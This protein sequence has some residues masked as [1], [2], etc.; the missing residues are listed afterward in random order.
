M[1]KIITS[2]LIFT[3][4]NIFSQITIQLP[5]NPIINKVPS[6]WKGYNK[7]ANSNL[8]WVQTQEFEEAFNELNPGIIRWPGGNYANSY[9]W[10]DHLTD[11]NNLNLKSFVPFIN[12]FGADMQIIVNFGNGSA[13]ESAEFVRFCNS[14]SKKYNELRNNVFN[15][16]KSLNVKFWEIGNENTD[17]WSFANSWFG[18]QENIY[19]QT[20]NSPHSMTR[21]QAERLY[22]YGGSFF[23]EGWVKAVAMNFEE[24]ILGD[25]KY[26]TKY[27]LKDTLNIKYP[28]LDKSIDSSIR[29]FRTKNFDFNWAKNITSQQLLYDSIS[30]TKNLLTSD[31][32][33]W[34]ET[35]VFLSPNG[36]FN[37]KDFILIEYNSTGHDGAFVFRDSMKAADPTI[38]VGYNSKINNELAN[39]YNFQIDFATSPPDFI[40]KHPYSGKLTI[41]FV[42][43]NMFSESAYVSE[44]K[45]QGFSSLQKTWN[46]RVV[47]WNIPNKIGIS[48]TEWNIA[49]YDKAP[50]NHPI[51]GI[52]SGLYVADFWA[53]S[54][55]YALKDSFILRTMNHFAL[56]TSGNNFIH[57]FHTNNE[58]SV[59]VEGKATT[60]V[61]QALSEGMFDIPV[62]NIPNINVV[63]VGVSSIDTIEVKAVSIFGGTGK[64]NEFINLLLINRDD[65]NNHS[66]NIEIPRSWNA[67]S[68]SI[69]TLNGTMINEFI[70]NK[71]MINKIVNNHISLNLAKYSVNTV[72]IRKKQTTINHKEEKMIE[73]I[74]PNPCSDFLY[75]NSSKKIKSFKIYNSI[76]QNVYSKSIIRTENKIDI[77]SLTSGMYFFIADETNN[78]FSFI[79]S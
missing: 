54:F 38:E 37:A 59:G 42:E 27:K 66:V 22:Y 60:M 58:F 76:G 72:K 18:Y 47:D 40:I 25:K 61:M 79:K 1:I 67:D 9:K 63:N 19:F 68:V 20:S 78:I 57:L 65:E 34:S 44:R 28:K 12:K 56:S 2:L 71:N 45:I 41:P 74:F 23:R 39:D 48:L 7:G 16:P 30:N 77:R 5:E 70:S 33:S 17:A 31:E 10:E 62:S 64:N 43:K 50:E 13:H 24:S 21:N 36:G 3:T 52:S 11:I 14:T 73:Y 35:Q 51:R 29:I 53:R 4:V 6:N 55:D 75:I 46:Q 32:Y 15:N 49:L 8:D 26:Y 69:E